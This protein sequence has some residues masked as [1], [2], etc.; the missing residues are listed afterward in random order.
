MKT[1]WIAHNWELNQSGVALQSFQLT[2]ILNP[3]GS[4]H[5]LNVLV[6]DWQEHQ[7]CAEGEY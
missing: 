6:E 3:R 2:D 5:L 1:Y 7:F 4:L